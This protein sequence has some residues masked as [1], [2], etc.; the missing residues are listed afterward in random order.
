[1]RNWTLGFTDVGSRAIHFKKHRKEFSEVMPTEIEYEL[2]ADAF[3]GGPLGQTTLECKRQ[4]GDIL[5]YDPASE[6]FGV[7]LKSGHIRTY[8]RC[9]QRIHGLSSNMEYFKRECN[10][11]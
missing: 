4:N 2:R 6:E 1:V 3:L 5:R 7:L 8:Y 11:L 9:D 10:R